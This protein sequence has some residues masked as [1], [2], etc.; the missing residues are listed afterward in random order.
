LEPQE[1][2]G[3]FR[4]RLR[5]RASPPNEGLTWGLMLT[6]DPF[7]KKVESYG[8]FS[9]TKAILEIGPGYGRLLKS[10]LSRKLP[11]REYLGVELSAKNVAYLN[12]TFPN[13]RVS[14]VHADAE[15]IAFSRKF[16]VVLSS[17]VFKHLYPSFERALAN[18]ASYANQGGFFFFDLLEGRRRNF[19]GKEGEGSAYVREYSKKE[20][21]GILRRTSLVLVKIDEV[22]HTPDHVR[23]LIVAKK[24]KEGRREGR[25]WFSS[26]LVR[27]P[28]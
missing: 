10:I 16:D 23:L 11:F 6:G 3:W 9:S 1:E 14:F 17:L 28:D 18:I 19:E 7:I 13:E 15:K 8:V 4:S 20:I 24:E 22:R 26:L 12:Q 5:W 2:Q 25:G 27:R 21:Q